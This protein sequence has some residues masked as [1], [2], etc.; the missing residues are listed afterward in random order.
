MTTG[1]LMNLRRVETENQCVK[2]YTH[3]MLQLLVDPPITVMT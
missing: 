3:L 1:E 2:N